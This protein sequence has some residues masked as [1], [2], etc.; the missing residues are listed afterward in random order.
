MSVPREHPKMLAQWNSPVRLYVRPAG[1]LSVSCL[2][3][4]TGAFC[5]CLGIE[6]VYTE[7]MIAY[8]RNYSS[9]KSILGYKKDVLSLR[10]QAS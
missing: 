5:R 9:L 1:P 2:A 4:K 8:V 7:H 3:M 6:A 10:N